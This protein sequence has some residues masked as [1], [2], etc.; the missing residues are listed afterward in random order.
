MEISSQE[1]LLVSIVKILDKLNIQYFITG[2]FAVSVWGRPRATFDID[3]VVKIIEPQVDKLVG[4]WKNLSK[5]GYADE[6]MMREA[7][8]LSGE[9]N[10]ID[11]DSGLKVN[12][13]VNKGGSA[14]TP[15]FEN[16]R[17]KRI[18]NQKVF[19]VSPEDLI[20]SK[21]QWYVLSESDRHINDIKSVFK[22]SEDILDNKYLHYW[23]DKLN[24]NDILKQKGIEF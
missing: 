6:N 17:F 22:I 3:I 14:N 11:P 21:L 23:V 13:W 7:I 4:A 12:F 24:L 19:F 1:K 9:F 5:A 15:E 18:N 10:F 16:R 2:G 20:L 8:K